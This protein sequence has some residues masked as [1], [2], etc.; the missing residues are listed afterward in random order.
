MSTIYD[1]A[2]RALHPVFAE[3]DTHGDPLTYCCCAGGCDMHPEAC[4]H[5]ACAAVWALDQADLLGYGIEAS[6]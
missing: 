5:Q 4:G 2:V 3:T 1:R 6:R